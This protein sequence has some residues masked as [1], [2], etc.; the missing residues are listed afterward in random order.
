MIEISVPTKNPSIN[1]PKEPTISHSRT[2]SVGSPRR[3]PPPSPAIESPKALSREERKLKEQLALFEKME[4]QDKKKRKRRTYGEPS[5]E[6]TSPTIKKDFEESEE[7]N[8]TGSS[9]KVDNETSESI[10]RDSPASV[11]DL[12]EKHEDE[13]EYKRKLDSLSASE[14]STFK[15]PKLENS[16]KNV[17]STPAPLVRKL[18]LKDFLQKRNQS[19]TPSP[20]SSTQFFP[21]E[22][23]VL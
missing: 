20:S 3:K 11:A 23:S 1:I 14:P 6:V 22:N 18:S 21:P 2:A 4:Q 7:E 19:K 17:Q 8:Y 16:E 9:S 10:G 13:P 5:T 12:T 15:K